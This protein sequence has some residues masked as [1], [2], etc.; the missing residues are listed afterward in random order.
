[1][2]L[3]KS[4]TNLEQSWQMKKNQLVTLNEMFFC[5]FL[6]ISCFIIQKSFS[7]IPLTKFKPSS[8]RLG[9]TF[10]WMRTL[11]YT[12]YFL[13]E[14]FILLNCPYSKTYFRPFNALY[15]RLVCFI[16]Y[17]TIPCLN[18]TIFIKPFLFIVP[19][20]WSLGAF[21]LL[22]GKGRERHYIHVL[23]VY[24]VKF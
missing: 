9:I 13:K 24:Q 2:F 8:S 21:M 19:F 10:F 18:L 22:Y 14:R 1:M 20:R 17:F 6:I 15:I 7:E 4:L 16:F 12:L 23:L 5:R 11:Q 3:Y